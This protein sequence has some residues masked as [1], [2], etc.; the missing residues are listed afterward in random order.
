MK[1]ITLSKVLTDEEVKNLKGKY[2][3]NEDIKHDIVDMD[4]DCFT[5][6]GNLLFKFRKGIISQE[7]TD[8]AWENYKGMAKASRGRG[9]SAG[10][11]DPN[12]TYWKKRIP[13]DTK[14]FSTKYMVKGK[15]SKMRVNNQVASQAIG[16]YEPTKSLGVDLPCRLTHYTRENFEKFKNG[17]PFIKRIDE[18]YSNL[19]HEKHSLQLGRARKKPNFQIED[20]AFSTM[21][22]NRNFQTGVHQDAGD[23]GFGNLAVLER[24]K[25]HGGYFVIPQYGIA[26]DLRQGDHLCV[27]VHQ[28][29][30]N[31]KMYETMSDKIYNEDLEDIFKDNA[32]VGT[33]GLDKKWTRISFVFYLRENIAIKCNAPKKYVINM[34][35]DK[36]KMKHH[37]G[38]QRWEAV[39]GKHINIDLVKSSQLYCRHNTKDAKVQGMYGCLQSHLGLLKYI[40]DEKIDDICILEDDST[41]D[42]IIPNEVRTAD[43]IT[44]LGG[45]RVNLKMKDIK[46]PMDETLKD[47]INHLKNSRVLTTRAYYIPKW[48]NAEDLLNYIKDKKVWK[49]YDLMMSEYVKHLYYPALS[50]QI[51]GYKSTIGNF[52]PKLKYE[53]Y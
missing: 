42:F 28:Y 46:K 35:H 14:G 37:K 2:L 44:Y 43:H 3:T 53:N 34:R 19:H 13:V 7:L 1:T 38:V 4:C 26:I 8:I 5:D 40:V 20:T 17:Y 25:Y 49:A 11:I 18:S 27:D 36:E 15:E 22:I 10:E 23:F 21:T 6:D 50:H 39:I 12:A 31:T 16:Y 51:V 32:K 41:S 48:K 45:W 47:G 33:L 29:H 30:G 9:A 24:G 52:S